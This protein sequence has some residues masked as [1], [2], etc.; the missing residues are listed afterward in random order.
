M[1]SNLTNSIRLLTTLA[2]AC[3]L[4]LAI[5]VEAI[6]E[7]KKLT[8]GKVSRQTISELKIYPGNRELVQGVY[9]DTLKSS[10]PDWN[11]IEERVFEQDEQETDG[12]GTH[13]GTAV[14]IFRDGRVIGATATDSF[15]RSPPSKG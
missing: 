13:R 2:V 7:K 9:S 10:D 8:Y 1:K 3:F 11:G 14:D 6:A 15:Q 4:V 12:T 5:S